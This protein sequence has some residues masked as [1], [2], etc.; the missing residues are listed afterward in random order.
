MASDRSFDPRFDP[1]FQ[2]GFDG[3]LV[4]PAVVERS[5]QVELTEASPAP[6]RVTLPLVEF[7]EAPSANDA[8]RTLRGN[9][10]IPALWV[11]AILL[12]GA[13]VAAQYFAQQIVYAPTA[14]SAVVAYVFPAVSAALSP[15]LFAVGLA[16]GVATMVIYALRWGPRG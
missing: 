10:W 8:P 9:P 3:G 1:A 13:G 14:S 16:T 11:T 5:A 6:P 2:R 15:W 12:T 7:V 4:G